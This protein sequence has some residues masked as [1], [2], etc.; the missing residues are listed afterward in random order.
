MAITLKTL[1]DKRRGEYV[2][3][4]SKLL[5]ESNEEVL[6]VKSN[7]IALPIVL[8]DGTEDFIKIVVSI[9]TG[10]KDEPYDAYSEA[11]FYE[12]TL[13][14]KEEKKKESDAKKKEKME[15][16]AQKRA[17]QKEIHERGEI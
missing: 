4:I 1:R 13:K 5:S 2:D 9:P 10:T 3:I 6:R 11:E 7:A 14:A 17:K 16:D 8:E 12:M 15:R